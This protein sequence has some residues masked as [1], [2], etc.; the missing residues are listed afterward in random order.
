MKFSFPTIETVGK[1][2]IKVIARFPYVV[3]SAVVGSLITIIGIESSGIVLLHVSMVAALGL[4]L[5]LALRLIRERISSRRAG[6][7]IEF[8][9]LAILV[10]YYFSF[11][12]DYKWNPYIHW[13]RFMVLNLGLHFFVAFVPCF[14]GAREWEYWQFNRRLYQRFALALLYPKFRS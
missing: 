8:I 4:P 9:G 3:L 2:T 7:A 11:P 14:T 10:G 6:L 1:E 5:M 12:P 13:M